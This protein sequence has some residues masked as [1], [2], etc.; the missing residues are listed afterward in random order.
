M[1]AVVPWL[2]IPLLLWLLF[3]TWRRQDTHDKWCLP[4]SLML[5]IAGG[6]LLGA[7]YAYHYALGDT[8]NFYSDSVAVADLARQDVR[9]YLTFMWDD[10]SATRYLQSISSVQ[11]RA[12]FMVKVASIAALLMNSNYWLM[13]SLFSV[14]GFACSWYLY[15][16]LVTLFPNARGAA[17]LAILFFPT[18]VLWSSGLI[19]ET[20]ALG[21]LFLLFAFFLDFW[22]RGRTNWWKIPVTLVAAWMLW[23]LKY[24]YLAAAAAP[25]VTCV[26][27]RIVTSRLLKLKSWLSTT[28]LWLVIFVVPLVALSFSRPNFY[29]ERFLHVIVENYAAY[30]A[31]SSPGE[32]IEYSHLEPT[33]GSVLANAPWALISAW[34]RP[35]IWEAHNTLQLLASIENTLLA[36]LFISAMWRWRRLP[37]AS[38]WSIVLLA[39]LAYVVGLSVFLALSTPNFGTL[40]RYRTGFLPVLVY[41]M[42]IDNKWLKKIHDHVQSRLNRLAP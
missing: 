22:N 35:F 6:S 30:E 34:F 38:T 40:N 1:S 33:W 31:L 8:L 17:A 25:M 9:G 18:V 5:R 39:A 21:L 42:S 28:V 7:L 15:R 32:R 2:L 24:Y 13:A 27:H 41:V 10:A 26:L 19:K 23:Q 14:F 20:L 3:R 29:A 16:V 4:L 36:G 37:P 12:V 11:P